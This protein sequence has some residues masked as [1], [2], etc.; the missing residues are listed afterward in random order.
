MGYTY[1]RTITLDHTK[2]P[3]NMTDFPVPIIDTLSYLATTAHGGHVQNANGYDVV[4]ALDDAGTMLLN[5]E[6]VSYDSTTGA[7]EYW[8]QVPTVSSTVDTV[9]YMVYGNSAITTDQSNPTGTWDSNYVAV[10]HFGSSSSLSVEDSTGVNDGTNHGA[11]AGTGL[12]GGAPGGAATFV[13]ASSQYVDI[14]TDPSILDL[15]TDVTIEAILK[16][17]PSATSFGVAFATIAGSNPMS[18][19]L[20]PYF[21]YGS[22]NVAYNL[23]NDYP[24]NAVTSA[25]S[26]YTITNPASVIL[27]VAGGTQTLY[28]D[29]V[30]VN[31]TSVAS[32]LADGAHGYIGTYAGFALFFGGLIDELRISKTNRSADYVTATYNTELVGVSSIGS[33]QNVPAGTPPLPNNPWLQRGPILA[34]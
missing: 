34:Q 26:G 14:G 7:V 15:T 20:A 22:G 33:E 29:G 17:D 11:T 13:Q 9:I 12:I 18:G 2:F 5:W 28:V 1:Y 27:V 24:T 3:S 32:P 30:D 23:Y 21:N 25:F 19:F 4:F 31:S 8:I 16:A 10:Y 6:V